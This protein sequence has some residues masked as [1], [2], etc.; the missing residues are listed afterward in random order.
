MQYAEP[1]ITIQC[2][3]SDLPIPDFGLRMT[4]GDQVTLTRSILQSSKD[5]IDHMRHG[6]LKIISQ[7]T[8]DLESLIKPQ[9]AKSV[10]EPQEKQVPQEKK[11]IGRNAGNVKSIPTTTISDIHITDLKRT[12]SNENNTIKDRIANVENLFS[13][14][15]GKIDQSLDDLAIIKNDLKQGLNTEVTKVIQNVLSP[16]S[17]TLSEM[18][19]IFYSD[20]MELID[21][22]QLVQTMKVVISECLNNIDSVDYG[23]IEEFIEKTFQR[24]MDGIDIKTDKIRTQTIAVSD[25]SKSI[26]PSLDSSQYIPGKFDTS[27]LVIDNLTSNLDEPA[28]TRVPKRKK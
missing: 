6:K 28:V 19:S 20:S 25:I 18:R 11:N 24:T 8:E 16:V 9:P 15:I 14:L 4:K 7:T 3:V 13:G 26:S 1:T 12:I 2:E 27:T 22:P 23:R 21:K 5:F 10:K 17:K